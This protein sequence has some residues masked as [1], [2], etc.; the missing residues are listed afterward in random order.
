MP[1]TSAIWMA[2]RLLR[3]VMG[4]FIIATNVQVGF[5]TM[6]TRRPNSSRGK[7]GSFVKGGSYRLTLSAKR[8]DAFVSTLLSPL[9][10]SEKLQSLMRRKP[11]WR[12][13]E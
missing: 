4:E 10:P 12:V 8:Y 1:L 6:K 7:R 3:F 13:A 5:I 9:Q 2:T 11:L